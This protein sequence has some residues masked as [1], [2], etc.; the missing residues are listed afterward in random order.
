MG[1]RSV[2]RYCLYAAFLSAA[3]VLANSALY[4]QPRSQ[5]FWVFFTDRGLSG[6]A[7][8][9]SSPQALGISERSLARRVKVL[10]SDRL[11]DERDLP[12]RSSYV[13]ELKLLGATIRTTSRWLNAASISMDPARL[14]DVQTL[15]FVADIEPVHKLG[16]PHPERLS[17]SEIPSTNLGG[18]SAALDYGPSLT[19]LTN[20]HVTDVHALGINGS[21]VLVGMIDDG[22]NNHRVHAALKNIRVV[23]EYDFIHKIPDTQ[24][25][26]W[27]TYFDG[28]MYQ[29]DHGAG[30][31][32][33]VA[34]FAP[35]KLIGGAFG[36][37]VALA[38]TEMD[39]S[40]STDFHSEEDTYVAGL[41]WEERLGV[42][43]ASSSLAYLL[44][45]DNVNYSYQNLDGKTTIVARAA[46]VAASK[47]VLLCTA[48]GNEG[49]TL[50]DST[51]TIV[52]ALK[53]L[54]SPADADSIL[55][56]GATTPDRLLAAFSGT[57]PSSDGR[58]KPDI[59]AQGTAI[60]WANGQT[61]S[62]YWT[63]QGTSC[64]TPLVA[65]VAA[66]VL[67]AHPELTPMQLRDAILQTAVRINDGTSQTSS[68]PNNLYGYGFVNALD[69]VLFNGIAFGNL[70]IVVSSGTS[71]VIT[72]WIKSKPSLSTDSLFLYYKPTAGGVFRRVQF[73]PSARADQY[74]VVVPTS[75]M[76]QSAACYVWARDNSGSIRT[77]PAA[78]PLSTFPLVP[79]PD[80]LRQFYPPPEALSVADTSTPVRFDLTQNYPNP[81]NGNTVIQVLVPWTADVDV[82]VFN[83]LGQHIR[84]LFA[85]RVTNRRTLA[86]NGTDD[87]GA[88]LSSGVY[89][90]RLSAGGF[91]KVL[92]MLYLK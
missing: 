61:T 12:V 53:T 62:S 50:R 54:W 30:T 82:S 77:S 83:V 23:A 22:F 46:R 15:P 17:I 1:L 45:T 34:G 24:R 37:S 84:T 14:S 55:A 80:S 56:V 48:M 5:N 39:S 72:A 73:I 59:V 16:A 74:Y 85:G 28:L 25:Q 18:L 58:T 76:D 67:S 69:A 44:F 35:G 20:I 79:T 41:E 91:S 21:G 7:L 13:E 63:L 57:G 49:F 47:G 81:F 64:S 3:A 4:G 40:G 89:Y 2:C 78:A 52:H 88:H 75:G 8:L 71:Y 43:I 51:G 11:V 33:S 36:V 6:T 87:G 92:K 66:L 27:E 10:P 90:Y 68:Y 38:K 70:P 32:S 86:W 65:S 19:Q 31:L 29:G 26:P 42:Q 60:Q 9:K